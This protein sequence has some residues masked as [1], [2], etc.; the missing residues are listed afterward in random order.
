[1]TPYKLSHDCEIDYTVISDTCPVCGANVAGWTEMMHQ[2]HYCQPRFPQI[3]E[4]IPPASEEVRLE[5]L[6]SDCLADDSRTDSPDHL[7]LNDWMT[8]ADARA[9]IARWHS[10]HYDKE[11]D[12]DRESYLAAYFYA[13]GRRDQAGAK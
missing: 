8:L 10:K 7:L 9:L 11:F 3:M 13:M 1:M 12:T 4:V 6:L 2:R 5:M